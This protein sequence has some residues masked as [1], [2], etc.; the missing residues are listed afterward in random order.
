MLLTVTERIRIRI[1]TMQVA[2]ELLSQENVCGGKI[3]FYYAPVI[4]LYTRGKK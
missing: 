3:G 4:L 2:S 1:F